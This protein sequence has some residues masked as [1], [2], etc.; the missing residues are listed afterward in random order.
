MTSTRS[1]GAH[2]SGGKDLQ[3]GLDQVQSLN[4]NA[5]QVFLASP[6]SMALP[7]THPHDQAWGKLIKD[8]EW[9]GY[10]H[11]QYML[12]PCS[13]KAHLRSRTTQVL[14]ATVARS[15]TLNFKGIVLHAGSG[16][17]TLK[18]EALH[19]MSVTLM[20]ILQQ[21]EGTNCRLLIEPSAGHKGTL[22]DSITSIPAYAE[23]LAWHPSLGFCLD[24]AHL[25]ETGESLDMAGG[26][27]KMVKQ[28]DKIVGVNRLGLMHV[29]DSGT[30]KGSRRD[31]H[32]SWGTG[33]VGNDC[34]LELQKDLPLSIPFVLET[35]GVNVTQDLELLHKIC[36]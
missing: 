16:G 28:F 26:T 17:V 27:S 9:S 13:D 2:V 30:P 31:L 18:E 29:N 22:S 25:L 11:T 19:R 34:L 7:S 35:P 15:L 4:M 36:R 20:P 1:Y 3:K 6:K 32:S 5:F 23:A 14:A 8:R 21:L 24:T 12:N 10:V 33:H